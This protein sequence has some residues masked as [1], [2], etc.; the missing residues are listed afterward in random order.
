MKLVL[1]QSCDYQQAN[2]HRRVSVI[3]LTVFTAPPPP[4]CRPLCICVLINPSICT[5]QLTAVIVSDQHSA[6]AQCVCVCAHSDLYTDIFTSIHTRFL[7]N[8]SLIYIP[9]SSCYFTTAQTENTGLNKHRNEQL[10][11]LLLGVFAQVVFS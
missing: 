3:V 4:V 8:N 2:Q 5:A 1:P 9:F 7:F 11:V 10:F 6:S